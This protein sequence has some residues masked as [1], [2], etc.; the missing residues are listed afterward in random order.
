MKSKLTGVIL[1]LLVFSMMFSSLTLH[2]ANASQITPQAKFAPNQLIIGFKSGIGKD[3]ISNFYNEHR[4]DYGLSDGQSL[5]TD[6]YGRIIKL[7]N[8]ASYV[9]SNIIESLKHDPRISYVEP[10]YILS[11]DAMG[12]NDPSA[13]NLWG[14]DNTG[15]TVNGITGTYDKDID[16]PEAW[17]ISKGSSS[18]VVGIIDTGID[19]THQDL[20]NNVWVNSGEIAGNNIDDDSNG[21]VDD[22]YGWNAIKNTGNNFD[23]NNHGTHVAGTI[24][25]VGNNSV[26]VV[27]INQQVKIIACKFLSSTG[28]GST[29]DAV[30]C[31]NYFS[32]LKSK[33]VN[34]VVTNNSWGGGGYSQALYDSMNNGILHAVAA[35][36]SG[37]DIDSSPSYPASYN[38]NNIISVAATDW[39]DNYAS[40][41]NYGITSVDI[42]APG[43][44]ILST[45]PGNKYAYYD[46]TS[47]AT[48]HVTGV[49]ALAWSAKPS[50]SASEVKSLMMQKGDPLS[51]NKTVSN[52][53]L[54]A[55]QVL[56]AL[57][58]LIASP[59]YTI[60]TSPSSVS[61]TAAGST[62]ATITINPVNGFSNSVTLSAS[63]LPSGMTASFSPSMTSSSSTATFN[64]GSQIVPGVYNIMISGTSGSITRSASI[65][66]T[67]KQPL[68][69]AVSTDKTTTYPVNSFAY[70]TVTA[71]DNNGKVSGASVSV[72]IK[73]PKNVSSSSTA[74]TDSTGKV[75]FKYKIGTIK[76]PYSI[77]SSGTA[78]GHNNSNIATGSFTAG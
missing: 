18:V 31:F 10:D 68:A 14:L 55:F 69:L 63:G 57:N 26:G 43:K 24:G 75:V 34:V 6:Q 54:N 20:V 21:Y 11:I 49:A 48:P 76:G 71:S 74:I 36:N 53:R 19:Y 72:T 42:G 35:G 4:A 27:G 73:D 2:V 9:D 44:N 70:I 37:V 15:Q 29:S 41:S 64:A 12:T 59:D 47:M 13:V 39:N 32:A 45:I 52:L 56:S 77:T 8:T 60:S 22:V 58:P 65:S 28:S 33:G 50:M 61:V 16:L 78:S 51:G 38:L 67:V 62:S 25:A 30:K 17:S 1:L 40:F 66:L 7:V 23:D 5:R 3:Q 46:G